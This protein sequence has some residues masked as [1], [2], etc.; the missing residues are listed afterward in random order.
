M[1]RNQARVAELTAQLEVAQMTARQDE[2]RAAEFEAAAARAALAQAAWRLGQKSVAAPMDALVH[3]TLYV[4]GEWIPAGSPVVSLLPP[5]NIKVRFFVPESDF[6]RLRT[7]DLISV[8]CDG[9]GEPITAPVTYISP[10][11]EYTPPVIYSRDTR[12]KL[13]F[14]IEARPA[15]ADAARL[16]PGQ[17][18]DV[19]LKAP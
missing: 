14:L 9:C 4:R 16:H 15:P 2:I 13:V 1:A 11:A 3:D 5:Q 7:G 17:P 18:V 8:S 12:T 6:G 19:R 10:Q